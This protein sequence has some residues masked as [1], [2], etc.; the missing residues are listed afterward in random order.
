MI[1]ENLCETINL[2]LLFVRF[3]AATRNQAFIFRH[4]VSLKDVSNARRDAWETDF[5][6]IDFPLTIDSCSR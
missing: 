3:S 4:G 2:P 1:N 5:K 6:P